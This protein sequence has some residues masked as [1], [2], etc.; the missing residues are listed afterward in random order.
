[1]KNCVCR[2]SGIFNRVLSGFVVGE[3]RVFLRIN[4][5]VREYGTN[6]PFQKCESVSFLVM[7]VAEGWLLLWDVLWEEV[8][9]QL[10]G[11]VCRT[12][13]GHSATGC[14]GL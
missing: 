4:S 6:T 14:R 3:E 10:W 8:G 9:E 1:M 7:L 13:E 2:V 12:M 11:G 5:T